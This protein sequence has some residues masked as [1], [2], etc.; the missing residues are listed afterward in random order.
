MYELV[1]VA[2]R[3]YYIESPA[4][5]GLYVDE[6]K[7]V[8]LIDTGSDKEAGRKIN[9]HLKANEWT[10]KR[11]VNTHSHA[12]HVGGNAFL[13]Q[14]A[15]AELLTTE[16][17]AV[18]TKFP[19][20]E[21]SLLYG[22][23]PPKP[24]RNKFLMAQPSVPTGV[25][26]ADLDGGFEIIPLPGHYFDMIGVRTPDDVLF[27]GDCLSG[28][29]IV[30]KYHVNFVYDV[31]QYL[32][33]LDSV[34]SINAKLYIPAHAS[35]VENILELT[36]INREKVQGIIAL[37]CALCQSPCSTEDIIKAVFDH[38]GLKMDFN[39]YVL[40]GSTLRSY[41]A[42]L[43]DKGCLEVIFEQNRLLFKAL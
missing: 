11:I 14:R 40:V 7:N 3:T 8:T 34:E 33:T 17:E 27:L 19:H 36:T 12:D 41:L 37:V 15:Q 30:E 35:P 38:F 39:Q 24:L 1:Q 26:G 23:F 25:V 31:E 13:Q 10:L 6:N 21:P 42:Y 28:A 16:V 4:K 22:G 9:Q 29:H 32:N 20:L 5:A 18:F 43:L 2:K